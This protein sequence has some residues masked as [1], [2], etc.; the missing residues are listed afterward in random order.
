MKI[1][2]DK[3]PHSLLLKFQGNIEGSLV[4]NIISNEAV[5]KTVKYKTGV[6]REKINVEWYS[7]L[8]EI[9]LITKE[10]KSGNIT[11]YYVF[12]YI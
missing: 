3:H 8:C 11:I 5:E 4:I 9:E 1:D 2:K 10:L 7:D 6:I 12:K